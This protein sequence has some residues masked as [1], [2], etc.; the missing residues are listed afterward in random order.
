[1]DFATLARLVERAKQGDWDA[2][3]DLYLAFTKRVYYLAL[4]ITKNEED[5]NDIVQETMI[6]LY[7][8]L[9]EIENPHAIGAYI[10]KLAYTQCTRFMRKKKLEMVE[11]DFDLL[12]LED[13]NEE[14]IPEKYL[15]KKERREYLIKL[16]DGLSDPLKV[17]TLLYYYNEYTVSH[18]AKLLDVSENTIKSR[19][20]R[21]R[22]AMKKK[23][24]SSK[25]DLTMQ[26][27]APIPV[28]TRILQA[29]ADEV[30]T[31]EI[32]VSIWQ[33]IAAKLGLSVEAIARTTTIVA[34]AANTA[35]S[36]A[37]ASTAAAAV[38][39]ASS[40]ATKTMIAIA[41]AAVVGGVT[42]MYQLSDADWFS[43]NTVET[44][45]DAATSI[46]YPD[47]LPSYH[48]GSNIFATP[49]EDISSNN[50]L[51]TTESTEAYEQFLPP[52]I[53][54]STI[55]YS[56]NALVLPPVGYD[57]PNVSSPETN[58][59]SHNEEGYYQ[60][61]IY[62]PELEPSEGVDEPSII[63]DSPEI[64]T[65]PSTIPYEPEI[66]HENPEVPEPP[67]IPAMPDPPITTTPPIS[68]PRPQT[69]NT[70]NEPPLLPEAPVIQ[71][72][73]QITIT[74]NELQITRGTRLTAEQILQAAGIS[75]ADAQ[76]R[77]IQLQV[78]YLDN[79]NFN[80]PG[81]HAVYVQIVY[82]GRILAQRAVV[83]EI[84]E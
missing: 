9:H 18:I 71:E 34:T 69:P 15:D 37:A 8:N 1:M 21:A 31:T 79:I 27:I 50:S 3:T 64:P 58:T 44:H 65:E 25:D 19:M 10:S 5:A 56:E 78:V 53:Q 84:T 17:V 82:D 47:I 70:P 30:F 66:P 75:A 36:A 68:P 80:T 55:L 60:E 24:E 29:H 6:A 20:L 33:G 38:T 63:I 74:N 14:F 73:P 40:M 23:I 49:N 62:V 35:S 13:H 11:A 2:F 48:A 42:A 16:V 28:L 83:I 39:A 22:A 26:S 81:R 57:S 52:V 59:I 76:G 45:N 72:T 54:D 51:T 67:E 46:Y 4:R 7:E 77:N 41:C 43:R 12:T 61:N 32:S